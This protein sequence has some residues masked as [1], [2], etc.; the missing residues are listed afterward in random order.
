MRFHERWIDTAC[1][2]V[3]PCG[4]VPE[5]PDAVAE[6]AWRSRLPKHAASL[7]RPLR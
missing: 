1:L 2:A 3:T 5:Y 6:N 4:E 7:R